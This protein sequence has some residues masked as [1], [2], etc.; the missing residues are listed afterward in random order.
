MLKGVLLRG[1]VQGLEYSSSSSGDARAGHG[2]GLAFR[3]REV[4]FTDIKTQI[5][6]VTSCQDIFGLRMMHG[7]ISH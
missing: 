5:V 1:I 2:E 4:Y 3:W 6:D 7:D